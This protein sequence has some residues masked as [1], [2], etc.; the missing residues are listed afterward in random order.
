M[1][2]V[3]LR[4]RTGQPRIK[5]C[6]DGSPEPG[7]TLRGSGMPTRSVG[8]AAPSWD[9]AAPSWDFAA[10]SWDFVAPSWDFVAPSCDFAAPPPGALSPPPGALPLIFL[11]RAPNELDPALAQAITSPNCAI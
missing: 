3:I 9:F 5:G 8:F 10:P 6:S 1:D 11:N 4:K 2:C 7:G